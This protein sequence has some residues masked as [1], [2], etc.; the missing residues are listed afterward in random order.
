MR[1][2]LSGATGSVGSAVARGLVQA[3]H[4]VTGL[5]SSEGKT[6]LLKAAGIAPIVGDMR[7]EAVITGA[8][9]KAEVIINCAMLKIKG[10]LTPKKMR[11]VEQAE[12]DHLRYIVNGASK[13]HARVIHT[14]GYLIY[15]AGADGWVDES[16]E[17]DAPKFSN[18]SILSTRFILEANE[19]GRIDGCLLAPGFVYGPDGF[20]LDMVNRIKS[21]KFGLPGGGNFYWSPV[22][23]EDLA[24]A[25][26]AALDGKGDGKSLL[27]VDDEPMLM[28]DIMFEV[29]DRLKV[30]RP[31]NVPTF[32]AKLFM[33]SA[34]VEV[35]MCSKRCRN[36]LAKKTLDW[37]LK[38][39]TF[40]D[41][42]QHVLD[43]IK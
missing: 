2:F 10:R 22:N 25:Y 5:T 20:F 28:K 11:L 19:Q 6:S 15:G 30:K 33:G 34:M 32:M 9:E 43:L 16:F 42:I 3:G 24:R 4:E 35:I 13:N 17:F 14:T 8:A 18:V 39:P 21:G 31:G 40:R 1:I 38:Y 36:N 7:D 12:M 23:S 29:A 41:G 27:I 26:I 37:R